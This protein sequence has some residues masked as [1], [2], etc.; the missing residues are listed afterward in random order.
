MKF[1]L[2]DFPQACAEPARLTG[3]SAWNY[4][5]PMAP[6]IVKL[7]EPRTFVELGTHAG[8]SY[9][10][11]C[12]AVATLGLSTQCA[13]V[14]TWTGDAHT[15]PYAPEIL[16]ELTAYHGPRYGGFSKLLRTTFDDAALQYATG[17]LDLL[18]IDGLHT[19]EAVRHDY[20]NWLPK[21]SRRGVVLFHD[22]AVRDRDFGVWKLWAEITSGR[23]HF[24]VPYGLGLG[25]LA[26]GPEVPAPFLDFLAELNAHSQV[27]LAQFHA[28]GHRNELLQDCRRYAE[29]LFHCLSV[30]N[31]W[32]QR[33]RQQCRLLVPNATVAASNPKYFAGIV[34]E[35]V[36]QLGVDALSLITEVMGLRNRK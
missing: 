17:A 8:D 29:S 14:D 31:D 1:N 10:A 19:Y 3:L 23:P 34:K 25:L 20:E 12:Q 18:H 21:L 28:L 32:R 24:E 26:V 13:A 33:T 16:S 22:T 4:H 11:F 2:S 30:T 9:I 35:D 36:Q 7:L 5:L 6:V 27:I 15:G